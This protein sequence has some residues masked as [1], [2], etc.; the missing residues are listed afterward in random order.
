MRRRLLSFA[1]KFFDRVVNSLFVLDFRENHVFVVVAEGVLE[2]TD[3]FATAVGAF[4]LA[5][6]EQI[7]LGDEALP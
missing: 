7:D 2:R 3:E 5:V 4:Y 1:E 6:T